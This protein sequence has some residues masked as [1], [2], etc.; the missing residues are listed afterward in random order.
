MPITST[1]YVG[2]AKDKGEDQFLVRFI[3][4]GGKALV[5]GRVASTCTPHENFVNQKH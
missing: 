4:F 1:G 3:P 2:V 5:L